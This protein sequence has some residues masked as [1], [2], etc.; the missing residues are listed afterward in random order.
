[1][2]YGM[3]AVHADAFCKLRYTVGAPIELPFESNPDFEC[4]RKDDDRS[5]QDQ[6]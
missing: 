4:F 2:Q 3:D 6:A 5:S 1:M